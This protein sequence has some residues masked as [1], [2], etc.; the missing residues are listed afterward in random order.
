MNGLLPI[1]RRKRRP[2][3]PELVVVVGVGP[4]AAPADQPAQETKPEVDD[5]RT[6]NR[7]R[8]GKPGTS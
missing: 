3:V 4:A 5:G 6:P 1:I 7:K 8:G 2:L